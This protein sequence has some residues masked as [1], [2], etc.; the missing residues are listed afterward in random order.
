MR[1]ITDTLDL[2]ILLRFLIHVSRQIGILSVSHVLRWALFS[3]SIDEQPRCPIHSFAYTQICRGETVYLREM[4][5]RIRVVSRELNFV[6]DE[7]VPGR[8][9]FPTFGSWFVEFDHPVEKEAKAVEIAASRKGQKEMSRVVEHGEDKS[10][11]SP[12]SVGNDLIPITVRQDLHALSAEIVDCRLSRRDGEK[13]RGERASDAEPCSVDF[14][15]GVGC[16]RVFE[17]TLWL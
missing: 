16:L 3:I 2:S 17:Y 10:T 5:R 12:R 14:H 6:L 11:N 7:F 1:I 8:Q 13:E 4:E 15:N 9:E